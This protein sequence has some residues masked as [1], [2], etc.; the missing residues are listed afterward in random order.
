MAATSSSYY[1]IHHRRRPRRHRQKK[2]LFTK[3]CKIMQLILSGTLRM[4][5]ANE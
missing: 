5:I 4:H 3:I 1:V 2:I